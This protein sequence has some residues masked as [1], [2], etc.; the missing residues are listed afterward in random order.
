[1][2]LSL[3]ATITMRQSTISQSTGYL[4]ITEHLGQ[5][6]FRKNFNA[7]ELIINLLLGT[8]GGGVF[9]TLEKSD[10]NGS[11]WTQLQ[12]GVMAFRPNEP[13]NYNRVGSGNAFT[14]IYP[15]DAQDSSN[16]WYRFKLTPADGNTPAPAN[17]CVVATFVAD[18]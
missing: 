16:T 17:A 8:V 7:K 12:D 11:T 18:V 6:T 14:G 4:P 2:V 9:L 1:M 13:A 15:L 5:T 3:Q 10:N